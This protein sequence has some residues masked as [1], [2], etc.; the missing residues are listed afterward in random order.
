MR[1]GRVH[2]RR[3]FALPGDPRQG[4]YH[5]C[6]DKFPRLIHRARHAV[7]E[8]VR[9]RESLPRPGRL[10]DRRGHQRAGSGRH[11]R[12]KPDA[13]ARGAPRRG[14]MVRR[15]GARP[16]A[17]RGRRRLE[18]DQGSDRSRPARR[19][20]RRRRRARGHALLQQADPGR[21]LSALQGDQRRHRHSDHHLQHPAT[22]GD[23]HVGRHHEAA[24]TSSRTSPASRMR[25]PMSSRVSQQRARHGRGL[26]SALRRGCDRAGLH[27]AWR[28][29]LHLGDLERGAAAVRR[30]PGLPASRTITRARSSCRTS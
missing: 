19:E 24:V 18:L 4:S 27:G 14:R 11:H 13:V 1:H 17:G 9:R 6:Q 28:A 21:P 29:R 15:P 30:I 26:Q 5:D 16:R 20:G 3:R 2:C 8:R 12:R 22:L 10:A 25:P 23:R 7:Q